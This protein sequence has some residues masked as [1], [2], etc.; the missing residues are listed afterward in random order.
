[1][2]N[3]V[4]CGACTCGACTTVPVTNLHIELRASRQLKTIRVEV[5]ASTYLQNKTIKLTLI[6]SLIDIRQSTLD[7]PFKVLYSSSIAWSLRQL[8]QI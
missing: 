6:H 2:L 7:T 4:F 3:L 1:M 8:H 5:Y